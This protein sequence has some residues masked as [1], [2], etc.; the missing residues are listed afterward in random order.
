MIFNINIIII[1]NLYIFI[2]TIQFKIAITEQ[3]RTVNN[4]NIILYL[5]NN[6]NITVQ[7]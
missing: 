5:K 1:L 7:L 2:S 4:Y 3:I 6:F